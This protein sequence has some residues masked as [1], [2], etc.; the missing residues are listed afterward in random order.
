[1]EKKEKLGKK[2]GKKTKNGDGVSYLRGGREGRGGGGG[3]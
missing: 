3:I 2:A 1:M